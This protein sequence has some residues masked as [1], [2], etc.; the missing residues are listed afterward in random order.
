VLSRSKIY[1]TGPR[2]ARKNATKW[3]GASQMG[4]KGIAGYPNATAPQCDVISMK[5]AS[6]FHADENEKAPPE[7]GS[8]L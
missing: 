3:S 4:K 1:K 6:R 5:R 8:L 7:R 2:G